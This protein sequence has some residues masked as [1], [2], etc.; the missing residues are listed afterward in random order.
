MFSM[1]GDYVSIMRTYCVAVGVLVTPLYY[2]FLAAVY[3][4]P[5]FFLIYSTCWISG[6]ENWRYSYAGKASGMLARWMLYSMPM[7]LL[8]EMLPGYGISMFWHSAA[9]RITCGLWLF[10]VI[11]AVVKPGWWSAWRGQISEEEQQAKIMRELVRNGEE[12]KAAAMKAEVPAARS[13]KQTNRQNEELPKSAK[14]D[15]PLKPDLRRQ[16]Q[17]ALQTCLEKAGAL[18]EKTASLKK[19]LD[20]S[21]DQV[22]AQ[23]KDLKTAVSNKKAVQKPVEKVS[24]A[25]CLP[26]QAGGSPKSVRQQRLETEIFD[27][28][29][30]GF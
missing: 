6:A 5:I 24:T 10:I 7:I 20:E 13:V 30:F 14:E 26:L 23:M 1:L 16:A 4:I 9:A 27:D 28:G 25:G 11:G 29:L 12:E 19:N 22:R 18:K 2:L 21:C 3:L 8:V 15:A 17:N